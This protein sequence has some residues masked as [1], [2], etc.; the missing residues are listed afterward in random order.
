VYGRKVD[1][2]HGMLYVD[3]SVTMLSEGMS[4]SWSIVDS[5]AMPCG[6]YEVEVIRSS[7]NTIKAVYINIQRAPIAMLWRAVGEDSMFKAKVWTSSYD[8]AVESGIED[9]A[10]RSDGVVS[11]PGYDLTTC[12]K[13]KP[14]CT[15]EVY[16]TLPDDGSILM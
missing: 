13:I 1:G 9:G 14:D 8:K 4:P 15:V 5:N 10:P 12:I 3:D 16:I 11:H 6:L 7:V 2:V